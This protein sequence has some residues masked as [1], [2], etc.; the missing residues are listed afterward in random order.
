[1][2]LLAGL[3][4]DSAR[5]LERQKKGDEAKAIFAKAA[6]DYEQSAIINPARPGPYLHLAELLLGPLKESARA[7]KVLSDA[8]QHLHQPPAIVYYL[9][10]A[11][12]KAKHFQEAA[13]TIE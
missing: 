9:A 1:Y 2:D 5:A 3:L 10:I 12:R 8:R 13:I 6:A 4:D 11:Q 7:I